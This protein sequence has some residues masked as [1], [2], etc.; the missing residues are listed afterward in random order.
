MYVTE[1]Q[2]VLSKV[3]ETR[4]VKIN[5]KGTKNTENGAK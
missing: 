4:L 3:D 5:W 2:G 1:S